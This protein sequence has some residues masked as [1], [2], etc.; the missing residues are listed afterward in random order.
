[1]NGIELKMSLKMS[2]YVIVEISIQDLKEYE[3]Y[4]KLTPATIAAYD[5]KFVVRGGQTEML[6]G[7]WQPERIVV[8]EFPTVERAKEWWSSEAYSKAKSIRQR[9]AR[10]KMIVVQGA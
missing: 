6:E 5:G 3:E 2:A 4:K 9:S 8:L 7:D 10:T 1:V